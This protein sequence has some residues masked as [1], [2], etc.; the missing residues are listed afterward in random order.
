MSDQEALQRVAANVRR[1]RE[2]LGLSMAALGRRIGNHACA[3]E[4]IEKQ[5]HMPGLGLVTRLAE[6]LDVSIDDLLQ[7]SKAKAGVA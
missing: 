2:E 1:L 6:A 4:K 3:I 7:K 5:I